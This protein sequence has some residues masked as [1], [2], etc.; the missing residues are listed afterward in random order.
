LR[1]GSASTFAVSAAQVAASIGMSGSSR[2]ASSV[3]I[4]SSTRHM[5]EAMEWGVMT[6]T[7]PSAS[8]MPARIALI[9]SDADGMSVRSTHVFQPRPASNSDARLT[10]G[11]S[12]RA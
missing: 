9:Q 12:T 2:F 4:D 6:N 11:A 7:T 5:R 10:S 3:A 8:S 1:L